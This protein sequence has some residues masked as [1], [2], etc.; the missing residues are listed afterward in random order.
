MQD[1]NQV[2]QPSFVSYPQ[3]VTNLFKT[4]ETD[5]ATL[6]HAT[7][8][9]AGET[10]ELLEAFRDFRAVPLVS[11]SNGDLDAFYKELGDWRFYTQA[12][13]N[14]YGWEMDSFVLPMP[15]SSGGLS[16]AIENMII[17][18][19]AALDLSKKDWVTG[20]EVDARLLLEQMEGAL[21]GYRDVLFYVGVTDEH[22]CELNREKL[23]L[24]HPSGAYS[25]AAQIARADNADEFQPAFVNTGA[26]A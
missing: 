9:M 16:V 20:K 19:G 13:W 25:D 6:H 8:G 10:A 11:L 1:N 17:H 12:V 2:V 22:I 5:A 7:T 14:I 23:A 15:G 24:R 3:M 4:L 21:A 18:S 26:S